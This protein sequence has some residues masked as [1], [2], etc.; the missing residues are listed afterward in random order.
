MQENSFDHKLS[1]LSQSASIRLPPTRGMPN[2]SRDGVEPKLN[3][4]ITFEISFI[5]HTKLIKVQILFELSVSVYTSNA[6][7][8]SSSLFIGV[9]YLIATCIKYAVI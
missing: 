1:Q 7:A 4:T 3:G 5:E 2:L 9:N 6:Q 8:R